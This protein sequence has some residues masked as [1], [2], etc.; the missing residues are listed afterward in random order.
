MGRGGGLVGGELLEILIVVLEEL[1]EAREE[2]R[3]AGDREVGRPAPHFGG[4]V[5]LPSL[6]FRS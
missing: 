2:L 5:T 1:E 4:D 3:H 6:M